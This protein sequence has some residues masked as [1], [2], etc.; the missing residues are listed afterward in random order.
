[1]G[2]NWTSRTFCTAARTRCRK[3]DEFGPVTLPEDGYFVMGDNREASY[4][5]RMFG[6][7][8]RERITGRA[9]Y[10]YFPGWAGSGKWSE[11]LGMA[12]K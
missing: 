12:L 11:R 10:I 3:G 2:V 9:L 7:V 8:Q 5:S 6:P 1:M 4:D